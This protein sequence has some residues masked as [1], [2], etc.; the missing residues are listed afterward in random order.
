MSEAQPALD[1]RL[2]ELARRVDETSRAASDQTVG[3]VRVA[4]DM[5]EAVEAF[6]KEGIT[7]I[8]RAIVNHP[9]GDDI[10]ASLAADPFAQALLTMHGLV[11]PGLEQRIQEGL[12]DARPWL[13]EHGGDVEFVARIGK[14]VKVR[15][16]GSCTDCTLADLTLREAVF[17]AVKRK[18]PEI[19][20]VELFQDPKDQ[21]AQAHGH[22]DRE[23]VTIEHPGEG[24]ELGP[25]L[26]ELPEEVTMRFD[27]SK[28]SLLIHRSGETI[29]AY[30][31][32]CPHKGLA[33]D[34]GLHTE[35]SSGE[36]TCP[37]HGWRFDL[38]TGDC[39]HMGDAR[40][41][42]VPL[43]LRGGAVWLRP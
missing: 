40:L 38:G 18:A 15:L 7:R 25:H 28:E 27:T 5:R 9:A 24:W 36:L 20:S 4:F 11:K 22:T 17:N 35:N 13:R 14:V 42:P 8:L 30:Y 43:L 31:N 26:D 33:L 39:V 3:A 16:S 21:G 32:S 41:V 12:V 23:K 34:G 19:E 29:R 2:E 37:W 10:A 6:H 1:D